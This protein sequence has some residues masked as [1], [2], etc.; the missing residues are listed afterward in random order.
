ME[1]STEELKEIKSYLKSAHKMAHSE[2]WNES[3]AQ[4]LIVDLGTLYEEIW[5]QEADD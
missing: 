3:R 1:I 2:D 5:P 4:E